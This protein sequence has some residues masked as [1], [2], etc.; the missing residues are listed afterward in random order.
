[1]IDTP[2]SSWVNPKISIK[3]SPLGGMG[4]FATE[5]ISEGEEVLIWGGEYVSE[6]KAAEAEKEGKLVMQWDTDLFSV[7][8]KG[9][10]E[11]YYINH[12]CDPNVWMTGSNTLVARR[13]ISKGEEL[14]ADYAM[15]EAD[16]NYVSTWNCS[17][18]SDKCRDKVTGKDWR[19]PELQEA[20]KEHFSP[21]INKRIN[22]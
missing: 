14:T 16:E 6:D 5:D 7:E 3:E 15:W 12:S 20:Y 4:M 1:M 13:D 22:Q 8:D 9:D 19:L 18:G 17:C 2:N 10:D 21:L 11:A